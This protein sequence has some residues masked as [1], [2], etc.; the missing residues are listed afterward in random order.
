MLNISH[1]LKHLLSKKGKSIYQLLNKLAITSWAK[2]CSCWKC[3]DASHNIHYRINNYCNCEFMLYNWA[4]FSVAQRI[5]SCSQLTFFFLVSKFAFQEVSRLC[6]WFQW[7]EFKKCF[8]FMLCI[9]ILLAYQICHSIT[10][11]VY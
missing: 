10:V 11:K 5:Q 6:F 7:V 8:L 9:I 1:M 2:L 3:S 4:Y